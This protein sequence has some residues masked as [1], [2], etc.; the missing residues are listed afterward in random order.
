MTLARCNVQ[1]LWNES[2]I[3]VAGVATENS[4]GSSGYAH[5]DQG[6]NPV[7]EGNLAGD[8]RVGCKGTQTC[9]GRTCWS[10]LLSGPPALGCARVLL[11]DAWPTFGL[12]WTLPGSCHVAG[13][14]HAAMPR[15]MG[16]T[17]DMARR[18]PFAMPHFAARYKFTV[19]KTREGQTVL[20]RSPNN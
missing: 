17:C 19:S 13:L 8:A 18:H 15:T 3:Q 20:T 5:G 2:F 9:R 11:T 4:R 6:C 1:H 16:A 14:R 12:Q 10:L 7:P